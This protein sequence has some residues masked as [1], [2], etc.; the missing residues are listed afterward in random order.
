MAPRPLSRPQV[1]LLRR[2]AVTAWALDCVHGGE[3]YTARSL[4]RRGFMQTIRGAD[5]VLYAKVLP[6]GRDAAARSKIR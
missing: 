2:I 3:V 4:A 5:G 6:E 1:M